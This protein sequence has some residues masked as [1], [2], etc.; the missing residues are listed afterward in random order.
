[1]QPECHLL[2]KYISITL[3]ICCRSYI[4]HVKSDDTIYMADLKSLLHNSE[5]RQLTIS[6]EASNYL[7]VIQ[8][9]LKRKSR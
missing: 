8:T 6:F 4:F 9:L 1:M 5:R 7:F 3:G 2:D